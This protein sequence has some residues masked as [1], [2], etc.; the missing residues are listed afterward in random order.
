MRERALPVGGNLEISA[1]AARGT[2]VR[3][4]VPVT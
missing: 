2:D 1:S 3:L 4:R